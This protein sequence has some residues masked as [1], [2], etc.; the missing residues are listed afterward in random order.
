VFDL[1][2]HDP[3]GGIDGRP[4]PLSS[5]AAEAEPFGS[6][7][8]DN[9]EDELQK[10]DSSEDL[11]RIGT[12][13]SCRPS[14]RQLQ[15]FPA[16]SFPRAA[17]RRLRKRP[18]RRFGED[19]TVLDPTSL[20]ATESRQALAH[21]A[22]RR[23]TN[24]RFPPRPRPNARPKPRRKRADPWGPSAAGTEARGR[25]PT[26][27]SFE[28]LPNH[29]PASSG[30]RGHAARPSPSS[31]R[32]GDCQ[33]AHSRR[34]WPRPALTPNPKDPTP[35]VATAKLAES[36]GGWRSVESWKNEKAVERC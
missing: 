28:S 32:H 2:H 20:S 29:P 30:E 17:L 26:A 6:S 1:W 7:R 9:F 13:T 15:P 33:S 23:A 10:P 19:D 8:Q 36:A 3:S 18:I 12:L 5:R 31:S 27:P 35:T 34:N 14:T 22:A 4:T 11:S 24:R 21:W 25:G 16:D